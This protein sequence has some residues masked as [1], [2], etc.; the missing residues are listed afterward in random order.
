ML[1]AISDIYIYK[2]NRV[3]SQNEFI[4]MTAALTCPTYHVIVISE[5]AGIICA[6]LLKK[7]FTL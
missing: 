7:I 3:N 1:V 2:M 5:P 4:M 6:F